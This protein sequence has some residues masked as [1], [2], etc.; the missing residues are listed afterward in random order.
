[1]KIKSIRNLKNLDN[2]RI[3]LRVDYNVPVKGG[4]VQDDY[5]IVKQL[6]TLRFLLEKNC[7]LVLLT[8]LGQPEPGQKE[9]KFKLGPVCDR[10]SHLMGKKVEY[11]EDLIGFKA[12]TAVAKMAAGDIVLLDN[13]RF[14]KGEL[15][16]SKGFAQK[17]AKYGDIYVNDAFGVSHRAQAS[18]SAITGFLP[19]YAGLLLE[20]EVVG[21]SKSLESDGPRVAIIGGAKL[22]TKIP[23]IEKLNK[24]ADH[25]L[26]GGALANDFLVAHN[27]EVGKSLV[28]NDGIFFVRKFVSKKILLP[29]DVVVSTSQ[30]G[31][32]AMV[33]SINKVDKD[34]Y[35]LDIGPDTV[36]LYANIIKQANTLIWNG[37]MGFFELKDFRHGTLAIARLIAARSKGKA[38]GVVGG[39]ETVE[40]LKMSKMLVYVDWVS[41]GGGAMLSFLGGE[42]M[43][44]LKG[45]SI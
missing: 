15:D 22:G 36:K 37:P 31:G 13:V 11:V 39:G 4:K 44:G 17:L 8:H 30:D 21:L 26:V 32:V 18:V 5:K 14:E 10:L 42:K 35:I 27:L 40:A 16:N 29:V 43:P 12:G 28:D 2:K 45:V 34:D 24:V 41:T 19:S 38:F 25:I 23:L 20:D 33:K 3:L 9:E 6:T 1:M 7:K